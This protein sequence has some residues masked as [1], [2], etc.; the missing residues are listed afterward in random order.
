MMSSSQHR[1][2]YLVTLFQTLVTP[3]AMNGVGVSEKLVKMWLVNPTKRR[4]WAGKPQALVPTAIFNRANFDKH[5]WCYKP[6]TF[7]D[8][9]QRSSDSKLCTTVALRF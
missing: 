6:N 3:V 9:P 5:G 4:P 8:R 2:K 7:I 1:A